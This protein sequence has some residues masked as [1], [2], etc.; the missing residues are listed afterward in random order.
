MKPAAEDKEATWQVKKAAGELAEDGGKQGPH[1]AAYRTVP[2]YI[3][4]RMPREP[5]ER[6]DKQQMIPGGPGGEA[7]NEEDVGKLRTTSMDE[8]PRPPAPVP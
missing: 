4:G 5:G 7:T 1:C 6:D 3:E 8:A 2:A